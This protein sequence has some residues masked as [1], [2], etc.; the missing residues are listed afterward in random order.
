IKHRTRAHRS[1]FREWITASLPLEAEG[2]QNIPRPGQLTVQVQ[3]HQI[4]DAFSRTPWYGCAAKVFHGYA[5]Q[6]RTNG[7]RDLLG[8]LDGFGVVILTNGLPVLIRANHSFDL[9][10]GGSK[11][12]DL[13]RCPKARPILYTL[14]R[15][16]K[17]GT[18]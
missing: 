13:A 2:V 15:R 5:R 18:R 10:H 14:S 4:H 8:D 12:F 16:I 1:V 11:P 7:R 17:C 6:V 3:Q 9:S